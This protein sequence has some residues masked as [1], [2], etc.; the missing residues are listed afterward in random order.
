MKGVRER[1]KI[2]V[3]PFRPF[4][5]LPSPPLFFLLPC[6]LTREHSYSTEYFLRILNFFR[7]EGAVVH[8]LVLTI[9]QIHVLQA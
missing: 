2:S 8:R 1:G 5:S 4:L 7:E 9:F 3:F 6:R